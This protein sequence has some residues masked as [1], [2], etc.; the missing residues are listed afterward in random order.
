M[1]GTR[2]TLV[3]VGVALVAAGAYFLL[4][5]VPPGTYLA[6][7]AWFAGALVVHDG[8]IAP[9]VFGL[10]LLLRRA[11]TRIPWAVLAI[12]QAALVVAAVFAAVV[13]PAALKKGIGTANPTLLPLEYSRNLLLFYAVLVVLTAAAIGLYLA[14]AR[15]AR[16]HRAP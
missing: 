13:I 2:V 8:I 12:V 1:R 10:S 16:A 3:V 5:G 11:G 7:V 9:V 14:V 15:R 6:I 4:A